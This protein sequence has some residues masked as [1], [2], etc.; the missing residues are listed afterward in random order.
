[1]CEKAICVTAPIA[2][3]ADLPRSGSPQTIGLV[4]ARAVDSDVV[5]DAGHYLPALYLAINLA[6]DTASTDLFPE[7]PGGDG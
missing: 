3:P 6:G 1:M 2:I 7:P 5:A 4:H